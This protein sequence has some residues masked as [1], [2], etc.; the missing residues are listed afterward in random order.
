MIKKPERKTPK[1]TGKKSNKTSE[2]DSENDDNKAAEEDKAL[3]SSPNEDSP[4]S[5]AKQPKNR[6]TIKWHG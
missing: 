4:S 6:S 1:K 3:Q 5:K 2:N